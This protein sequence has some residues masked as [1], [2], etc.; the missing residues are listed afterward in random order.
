M[1]PILD[2]NKIPK[3]YWYEKEWLGIDAH[4]LEP[5]YFH[6]LGIDPET[7]ETI[8]PD[9]MGL[10]VYRKIQNLAHNQAHVGLASEIL[11]VIS[12]ARKILSDVKQ[13]EI[14]IKELITAYKKYAENLLNDLES[15]EH[16]EP[17]NYKLVYDSISDDRSL[18]SLTKSQADSIIRDLKG[19][20]EKSRDPASPTF[21]EL[22]ELPETIDDQQ[23]SLINRNC[24]RLCSELKLKDNQ[25]VNV[26]L[27]QKYEEMID[28]IKQGA[29]ILKSGYKRNQ[30]KQNILE[31]RLNTFETLSKG[32]I[33][34]AR[35]ITEKQLDKLIKKGSEINLSG[36]D[37]KRFLD[38]KNI[39]YPSG[40][41]PG[42]LSF[43]P[44]LQLPSSKPGPSHSFSFPLKNV[45][46]KKISVRLVP[47][48]KCITL[49]TGSRQFEI[50]KKGS[51][52]VNGKMDTSGLPPGVQSFKIDVQGPG[53][54]PI[55]VFITIIT[56]IPRLRPIA[57]LDFGNKLVGF[58][59]SDAIVLANEGE[60]FLDCQ[61]SA[62]QPWIKLSL[63]SVHIAEG[64]EQKIG[65][66]IVMPD[67]NPGA[68][69]GK[70]T[71]KWNNNVTPVSVSVTFAKPKPGR[72][73]A[74]QTAFDLG[75]IDP[76][77]E[78]YFSV[79]LINTGDEPSEGEFVQKSGSHIVPDASLG[80]KS[81]YLAPGEKRKFVFL[82]RKGASIIGQSTVS[83]K[84]GISATKGLIGTPEFIVHYQIWRKPN[85][86]E[87]F[88]FSLA[89]MAPLIL[90]A[91][92]L[93]SLKYPFYVYKTRIPILYGFY[94]GA[95]SIP[96]GIWLIRKL[97]TGRDSYNILV[98]SQNNFG[99]N[100]IWAIFLMSVI[101]F[102]FGSIFR[103]I[104]VG[105]FR[106]PSHYADPIGNSVIGAILGYFLAF[107]LFDLELVEKAEIRN[108]FAFLFAGVVGVAC[109]VGGKFWDLSEYG[110]FV[111]YA[112][113]GI[114]IPVASVITI[115]QESIR[116]ERKISIPVSLIGVPLFLLFIIGAYL[117][118]PPIE[119][120]Q[121]TNPD[122]I[123]KSDAYFN[124]TQ[125]YGNWE[126]G[127]YAG[128]IESAGFKEMT[129]FSNGTWYVDKN[130][131]RT[132]ISKR[133]FQSHHVLT[134]WV[135]AVQR[136]TSNYEGKVHIS[137][138]IADDAKGGG[139][140]ITAYII[141][142]GVTAWVEKI[143][144]GDTKG[145]QIDIEADLKKDSKVD[146][147]VVPG[148]CPQLDLTKVLV[149]ITKSTDNSPGQGR[150]IMGD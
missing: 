52:I 17:V 81:F 53:G 54:G 57:S 128:M 61:L 102:I 134:T 36:H 60:G 27:K 111:F 9:S 14:Y 133:G 92:L 50:D 67:K 114:V 47:N 137:G 104:L 121:S 59:L 32:I 28:K 5:T 34:G 30:Y 135:C 65:V 101:D 113:M 46:D 40:P 19:K 48:N 107:W 85:V 129:Q 38:G 49:D 141:I 99:M 31:M 24:D 87:Q 35:I 127:F 93:H 142:D 119:L 43:S 71:I 125:G 91:L 69:R 20:E 77:S 131:Y 126:Y 132:S 120:A 88:L 8:S 115:E 44:K 139:D 13:R 37:I 90:F 64:Q 29:E 108:S 68:Y 130:M 63:T 106:I 86:V 80:Q 110:T 98:S 62:D 1:E 73:E 2:T 70:I 103:A 45:G 149:T 138:N 124:G 75:K 25:T 4:I 105:I 109:L 66:R 51:V 143:S 145:K 117:Q 144:D 39:K 123:T 6:V 41:P 148:D 100:A 146:I 55:D 78:N 15:E 26:G 33:L 42:R 10:V 12:K 74:E 79:T 122:L 96:I 140:G 56:P 22:L 116:L 112:L 7:V 136:W 76:R 16:E 72:I 23:I 94:I 58:E 83:E 95:L 147:A 150:K 118:V 21:F 84:V 82:V 89:V 18:F 11:G 3:N 97:L